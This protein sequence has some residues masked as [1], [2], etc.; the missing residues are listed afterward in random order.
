MVKSVSVE[1]VITVNFTE[2]VVVGDL[3][4]LNNSLKI[5]VF[6]PMAEYT[7]KY[8]I[9]DPENITRD[10]SN[11]TELDIRLY[12]IE[13]HLFGD[14]EEQFQI[15]FK[16]TSLVEDLSGNILSQNSVLGYLNYYDYID[17]G[18]FFHKI[19]ATLRNVNT[20]GGSVTGTII[21]VFVMNLLFQIS[22]MSSDSLMW[23][24]IHSLQI[25]RYI[26][27]VNVKVPRVLDV[28]IKYLAITIGEVDVLYEKVPKVAGAIVSDSD[29][30]SNARISQRFVDSGKILVIFRL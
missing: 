16:D 15:I 14:R 10:S 28:F 19:I 6:G 21:I 1:N 18:K 12:D 26:Y 20:V 9:Y 13:T 25:I 22:A 4:A 17:T 8:E 11:I 7:F 29:L 24:L 23:S 30:H 2:P 27:M 5:S 3:D